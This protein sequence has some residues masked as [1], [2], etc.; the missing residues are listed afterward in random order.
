VYDEKYG[1]RLY[2]AYTDM[3]SGYPLDYCI[4]ADQIYLGPVPDDVTYKYQINYSTD[5]I[6]AI[7][8]ST[9]SVPF[10]TNYN[11][12]NILRSAVLSE[13]HD[14]MENYEEANYWRS[15]YLAGKDK[16]VTKDNRNV[17]DKDRVV[18]H[19]F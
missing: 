4:Y 11:E 6:T 9:T 2:D 13:M 5:D 16:M 10:T 19:G 18:Y 7:S 12:R 3:N 14:L 15:L 17:D 1:D 8:A